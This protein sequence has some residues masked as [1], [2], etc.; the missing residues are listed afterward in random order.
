QVTAPFVGAIDEPAIY[1]RS[2]SGA[3]ILAIY[4]AGSAGKCPPSSPSNCVTPPS[5]LVS[6][7]AAEGTATDSADS[8]AGTLLNG[9]GFAPGKVGQAFNFDGINDSIQVNDAPNLRFS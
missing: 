7:W 2:L 1:G 3:E 4:N 6:W 5:G 8:N 9:V